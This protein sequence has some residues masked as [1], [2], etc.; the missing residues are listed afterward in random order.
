MI[1]PQSYQ[2]QINEHYYSV[3]YLYIGK[4][5]DVYTSNDYIIVK[6]EGK[7]ICRHLRTDGE[8]RT[9]VDSHKPEAH[10]N[11]DRKTASTIQ[12]MMCLKSVKV[13]MTAYIVTAYQK[14]NSIRITIDQKK[15]PSVRA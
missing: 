3:P 2:I 6:Y 12:L 10:Q 9:V 7:E 15:L 13:W 8:G 14:S 4:R 11:I 5:V 1:V